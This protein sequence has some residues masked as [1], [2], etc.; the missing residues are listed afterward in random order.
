M[1]ELKLKRQL[2]NVS[3]VA[4][5][6]IAPSKPPKVPEE[7][8]SE[9]PILEI[10]HDATEPPITRICESLPSMSSEPTLGPAIVRS[11]V[12]PKVCDIEIVPVTAKLIVSAPG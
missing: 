1:V 6:L 12:I 11:S 7:A 3:C 5:E 4:S 9:N 10:V 8:P 2:F